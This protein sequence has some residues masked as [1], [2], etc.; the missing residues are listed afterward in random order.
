MIF[1]FIGSIL[2]VLV[3]VLG[4][5]GAHGL[6]HVLDDYGLSIY[7]K[8]V[9]YHMFHTLGIL[10]VGLL[11]KLDVNFSG[12]TSGCFFLIG[13]IL[14]SG[15]LYLMAIFNIKWLGMVTPFGGIAFVIGWLLL[16]KN[17]I[18]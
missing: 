1:L 8:A 15:S 16:A 3:V 18:N 14:F 12:E 4:A 5:F 7:N 10:I 2:G 17:Q 13:I 9:L 6:K 11:Q